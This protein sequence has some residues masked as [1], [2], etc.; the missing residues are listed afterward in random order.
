MTTTTP[1]LPSW[2]VILEHISQ[3]LPTLEP[4]FNSGSAERQLLRQALEHKTSIQDLHESPERQVLILYF[5]VILLMVMSMAQ[6]L[7]CPLIAGVTVKN[8]RLHFTWFGGILD[9]MAFGEW[10]DHMQLFIKTISSRLFPGK[11]ISGGFTQELFTLC[12]SSL[13]QATAVLEDTQS[14]IEMVIAHKNDIQSLLNQD[15]DHQMLFI[16]LSTLPNDILNDFFYQIALDIPENLELP[17]KTGMRLNIR[18]M[19]ETRTYDP[20]TLVI[21]VHNYFQLVAL[22]KFPQINLIT[23]KFTRSFVKEQMDNRKTQDYM[24]HNLNETLVH[25]ISG[26][27]RLYRAF[28][29]NYL[30]LGG[31][32]D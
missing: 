9:D 12:H 5:Q 13:E 2:L 18:T 31:Q 27:A 24:M 30:T 8:N 25:Q 10:D 14:K 28:Y 16:L 23:E 4:V 22:A 6:G 29:N 1:A 20:A 32:H 3:Q 26:R 19:F 21:K 7:H 17:N 11:S 15:Q